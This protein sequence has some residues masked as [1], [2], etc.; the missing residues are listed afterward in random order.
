MAFRPKNANSNSSSFNNEPR[1]IPTPKAG[2]RQARISL[3]VDLGEQNREDFEDDKG[4]TRP[5]K[6]CQQVAVFADLVRDVVDYGGN[7]GKAP[8]RIL[9]N[10][11]FAGKVQGVNFQAVPPKDADGNI[12]VGKPWTLHPA[13]LLTKLAK[14]T[15]NEDVIVSQD[16]SELLNGKFIADIKIT[17]K[18]TDKVDD[19]GNPIVYKYVNF[20]GA[21]KVAPV[22]DEDGNEREAIVPDLPSP[23]MCITFDDAKPEQIKFIRGNLLQMI[24]LANNYA[25]SQMQKAVEAYE[26]NPEQFGGSAKS[27]AS[28]D[29]PADKPAA[30]PKAAN[31]PKPAPPQTDLD[32]DGSDLPY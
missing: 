30:K 19:D 6:P 23:A 10:K 32:D 24:K 4:N 20:N 1:N 16:I 17:E 7:I 13:S 31:K 8:Y 5:Q 28:D 2:G 9:L 12:M 14:A 22:F 25:G 15:G 29:K 3:I 26:A 11:S 21:S 18:E 27:V